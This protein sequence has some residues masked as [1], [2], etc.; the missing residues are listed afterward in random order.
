AAGAELAPQRIDGA[1]PRRTR[2]DPRSRPRRQGLGS[3]AHRFLLARGGPARL[4]LLEAGR[5][6]SRALAFARRRLCLPSPARREPARGVTP[7]A[8]TR[9]PRPPA[10]SPAM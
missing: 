3:R 2:G 8:R 10:P 7:G 6:G 5:A 4:L 1:D 9:L